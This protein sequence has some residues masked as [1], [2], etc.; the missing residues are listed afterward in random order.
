MALTET[1][2]TSMHRP[3]YHSN[4]FGF[5]VVCTKTKKSMVPYLNFNKHAPL[6]TPG[7]IPASI[8]TYQKPKAEHLTKLYSIHWKFGEKKGIG[9]MGRSKLRMISCNIVN[10]DDS[11][12]IQEV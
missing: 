3:R 7:T 9:C 2:C 10:L 11:S 1:I 6:D 12:I 5:G 4:I 8:I